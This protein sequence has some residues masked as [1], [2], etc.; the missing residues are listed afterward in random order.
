MTLS[1]RDNPEGFHNL[2]DVGTLVPSGRLDKPYTAC[3]LQRQAPYRFRGFLVRAS[4]THPVRPGAWIA[5]N[6][7]F[8]SFPFTWGEI[9]KKISARSAIVASAMPDAERRRDAQFAPGT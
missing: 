3:R 4:R 5:H 7:V 8:P 6:R 1:R 9:Q 2:C